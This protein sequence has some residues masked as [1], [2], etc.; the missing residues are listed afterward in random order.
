MA[1]L[2]RLALAATV[3]AVA[4]ALAASASGQQAPS[5]EWAV[6]ASY[7]YK[8]APFIDWPPEVMPADGSPFRICVVGQ[9]PFGPILDAAVHGQEVEGHAIVVARMDAIDGDGRAGCRIVF[10]GQPTGQTTAATME[11]LAGAPVLTVTDHSHGVD[12]GMIEFVLDHG[13]VRFIVNA[14]AASASGLQISSKL[15]ALAARVVR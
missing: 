14:R 6:K 2:S 1:L 5:L 13:R 11:A 15:L 7:L 12:G 3:A 9:D 4:L 10:A 8:F